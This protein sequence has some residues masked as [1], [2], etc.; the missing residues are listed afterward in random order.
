MILL[1]YMLTCFCFTDVCD[2]TFFIMPVLVAAGIQIRHFADRFSK[3]FSQKFRLK[4]FGF[5]PECQEP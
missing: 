4:Q 2:I 1:F 5:F 3:F